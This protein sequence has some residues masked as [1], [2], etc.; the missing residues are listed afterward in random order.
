MRYHT[1]RRSAIKATGVL[2]GGSAVIKTASARPRQ[3]TAQLSTDAHE[4]SQTNARGQVGF[5]TRSDGLRF[6]L[7][8]ANI[9][10]VTMA[11]IHLDE[12]LGPVA[13]WLHDF[14][15]GAPSLVEGRVN[16]VL[17]EGTITD[18]DVIG[19]IITV[20]DLIDEIDAGDAWV[21]VHT[22]AFPGGEIG[23]LIQARN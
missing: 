9:E 22:Q 15:T 6:K 23:G 1:T 18:D 3:F 19:P 16:G 21:N 2:L 4:D 20:G 8:V 5:Q 7:I 10:D 13:V 12:V 11:H 14:D 17:S